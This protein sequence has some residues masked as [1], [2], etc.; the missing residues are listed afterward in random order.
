MADPI[1]TVVVGGSTVAETY[2]VPPQTPSQWIR[3]WRE[4]VEESDVVGDEDDELKTTWPTSEGEQN[5]STT[6]NSGETTA[7]FI[8]RHMI[9]VVEKM[10]TYPPDPS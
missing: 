1:K 2:H 5:A 7:E 3:A 9:D 10:L 8:L 4:D 6:R